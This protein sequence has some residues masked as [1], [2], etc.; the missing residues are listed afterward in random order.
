MSNSNNDSNNSKEKLVFCNCSYAKTIPEETKKQV[1]EGLLS[2]GVDMSFYA[3][4]CEMSAKKDPE[5][6]NVFSDQPVRIAACYER[7]LK[8]LA[9]AAGQTWHDEAVTVFN[10]KE[11][12]VADIVS[13]FTAG[14]TNAS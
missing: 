9:H 5:L 11:D 7:S 3:D 8:G 1:L 4:L 6:A 12:S 14:V 10:M 2:S 13:G